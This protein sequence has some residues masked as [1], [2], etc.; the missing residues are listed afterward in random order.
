MHRLSTELNW[1]SSR[2]KKPLL[3]K[4]LKLKLTKESLKV[5]QAEA[6][7]RK[8]ELGVANQGAF[9]HH[10][11]HCL[12]FQ[13]DDW[14]SINCYARYLN[15]SLH[16]CGSDEGDEDND[17][18]DDV[19]GD[20]DDDDGGAPPPLGLWCWIRR[21]RGV[22]RLEELA[23]HWTSDLRIMMSILSSSIYEDQTSV[24]FSPTNDNMKRGKGESGLPFCLPCQWVNRPLVHQPRV[25]QS[26]SCMFIH[27]T[28]SVHHCTFYIHISTECILAFHCFDSKTEW[29]SAEDL[30]L[31]K[32]WC[33]TPHFHAI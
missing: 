5:T 3:F 8:S 15:F 9:F 6:E 27:T 26:I 25:H 33:K 7:E 12:Q 18:G 19:D 23:T 22:A 30:H 11:N 16:N 32:E 20:G 4:S 13:E 24:H 2:T 29:E 10:R 31:N 14:W 28:T 21:Q 17:D 1:R